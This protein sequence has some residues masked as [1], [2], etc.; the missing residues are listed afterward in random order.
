M[1]NAFSNV[2]N[3]T[4]LLVKH[5]SV[6]HDFLR[7]ILIANTILKTVSLTEPITYFKRLYGWHVLLVKCACN[8]LCGYSCGCSKLDIPPYF[9]RHMPPTATEIWALIVRLKVRYELKHSDSNNILP[10]DYW[11]SL[12]STVVLFTHGFIFFLAILTKHVHG[13]VTISTVYER[14]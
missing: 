5:W 2:L 1:C 8:C 4:T 14:V 7:C 13:L 12:R 9:G 11:Y 6:T 10:L 3:T